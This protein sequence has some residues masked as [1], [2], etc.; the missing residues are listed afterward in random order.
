MVTGPGAQQTLETGKTTLNEDD[1]P[2]D[3]LTIDYVEQVKRPEGLLELSTG[4]ISITA[5]KHIAS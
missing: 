2:L 5:E 4:E 1:P 3:P